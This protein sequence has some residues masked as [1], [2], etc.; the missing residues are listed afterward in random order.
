[1]CLDV[2]IPA[3][4]LF[5]SL[6]IVFVYNDII[7]VRRYTGSW[8]FILNQADA[9]ILGGHTISPWAH[10]VLLRWPGLIPVLQVVYFG[11][12][13]QI[14]AAIVILALR[15]GKSMALK[16][17]GTAVTA[18]YIALFIFYWIPATGPFAISPEHFSVIRPGI[19]TY[20]IQKALLGILTQL[21]QF[22]TKDFIGADYFIALPSMH[23]VLPLI[24]LWFSRKWKRMV[25]V[26]IAYDVL[27]VFA[28]L[29]LEWHYVVDM[30]AALPV[31]ALVIAINGRN[32]PTVEVKCV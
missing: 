20:E 5:V 18:Y 4:Y 9:F 14:G 13:A 23:I 29:L 6:L 25:A 11:I 22:H 15:D 1:M 26:L 30:I 21:R 17:V 12:F 31:A 8:E 10:A 19:A 28:I 27:V 2:Y 24:V 16:F 7:A 32:S 3:L